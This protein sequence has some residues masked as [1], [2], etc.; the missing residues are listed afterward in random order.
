MTLDTESPQRRIASSM[1]RVACGKTPFFRLRKEVV[2][3][4][5][6]TDAQDIPHLAQS[7]PSLACKYVVHVS[8]FTL[9]GHEFAQMLL[10]EEILKVNQ[11]TSESITDMF[12]SWIVL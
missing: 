3:T 11:L 10:R 6:R 12:V 9:I 2:A 5:S 7:I 4:C 8:D 1:D